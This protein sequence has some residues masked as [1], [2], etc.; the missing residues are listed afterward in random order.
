MDQRD[1]R[2][3]AAICGLIAYLQTRDGYKNEW[4]R[5]GKEIIMKNRQMVQAKMFNRR[6]S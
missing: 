2:K 1:K 4:S 5:S 6:E 3:Q